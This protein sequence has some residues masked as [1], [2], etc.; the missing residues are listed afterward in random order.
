MKNEFKLE[1]FLPFQLTALSE[2]MSRSLSNQYRQTFEITVPEWRV[3]ASLSHYGTISAS[4]LGYRTSMEKPRVS[5][6]LVKMENRRLINKIAL[7]SD[8]RVRMIKLTNKGA[9][10]YAEIEPIAIK[11]EQ[12]LFAD[13]S[14]AEINCV[15]SVLCKLAKQLKRMEA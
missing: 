12:T 9:E 13:L 3:L 7:A 14:E 11:W 2:A 8:S 1:D 4:E 15:H 5:R 6:A 10:L